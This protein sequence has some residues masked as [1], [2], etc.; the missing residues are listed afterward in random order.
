MEASRKDGYRRQCCGR[1]PVLLLVV[2]NDGQQLSHRVFLWLCVAQLL[3][4]L[5]H[6][7]AVPCLVQVDAPRP[8][9]GPVRLAVPR[10]GHLELRP[11]LESEPL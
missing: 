11:Q 3:D 9:G 5:L 6:F 7:R 1:H 10:P 2:D 4:V 8:A